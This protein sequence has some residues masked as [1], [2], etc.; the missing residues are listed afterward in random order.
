MINLSPW[1]NILE[2]LKRSVLSVF[3]FC[4]THFSSR[5]IW[6]PPD[7]LVGFQTK[8]IYHCWLSCQIYH[9]N[10]LITLICTSILFALFLKRMQLGL[11]YHFEN[12]CTNL[13]PQSIDSSLIQ[14]ITMHPPTHSS[15]HTYTHPHI[16]SPTNPWTHLSTHSSNYIPF[17]PPTL[18]HL[19]IPIHL[20]ICNLFIHPSSIHPTIPSILYPFNHHSA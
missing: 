4:G 5:Q 7:L 17:H 13:Y 9:F 11:H 20:F 6:R 8:L 18:I 19:S 3:S 15:I 2:G 10:F 16:H 14:I 12:I 1:N